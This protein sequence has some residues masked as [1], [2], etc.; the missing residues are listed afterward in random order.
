MAVAQRFW[1]AHLGVPAS[2]GV[3]V[4][5][6]ATSVQAV[7][8]GD[9]SFVR[10]PSAVASATAQ[11]RMDAW[12]DPNVVSDLPFD[13]R[14]HA[15]LAYAD[16]SDVDPTSDPTV[17]TLRHDDS[18]V[19]SLARDLSDAE[20]E[21]SGLG[22][23]AELTGWHGIELAGR[24]VAIAAYENWD[25]LLAHVCV[26]TATDHR[27]RGHATNAARATV[28]HAF[29]A[30]LVAQWRSSVDNPASHAVGARLGFVDVGE[31][32]VYRPTS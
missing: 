31:Q 24:L 27:G 10:I 26:A 18:R 6:D 5:D 11:L 29:D 23:G 32:L 30:G 21:E 25:D 12:F 2:G 4:T 7:R 20:W 16:R 17:V 28:A 22:R 13:R 9:R 14:A 3:V 8:I 1:S 19:R 15:R